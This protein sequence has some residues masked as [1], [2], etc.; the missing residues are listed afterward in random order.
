MMQVQDKEEKSSIS[1]GLL[2]RMIKEELYQPWAATLM[3]TAIAVQAL[4]YLLLT[5]N[6]IPGT[7]LFVMSL[8]AATLVCA[9]VAQEPSAR[10]RFNPVAEWWAA[11]NFYTSLICWLFADTLSQRQEPIYFS[12]FIL[13]E[14]LAIATL[15]LS[16]MS[17]IVRIQRRSKR[18]TM[19]F[20]ERFLKNMEGRWAR[21]IPK[22]EHNERE[23]I[24][25]AMHG[26]QYV[27]DLFDMG[28]FSLAVLWCCS[29]IETMAD[30]LIKIAYAR[31]SAFDRKTALT[32]PSPKKLTALGFPQGRA[33]DTIGQ[34]DSSLNTVFHEI[35]GKIA[36][37]NNNPSF[38]ETCKA[39]I[40][41]RDFLSDF[42]LGSFLGP[43]G[44]QYF[45]ETLDH[46]KPSTHS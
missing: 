7:L 25:G 11:L 15:L 23:V 18:D 39:M 12:L 20:D 9:L 35:R 36:H 34:V 38:D 16:F 30:S 1:G 19:K 29:T 33:S 4:T 41:L 6:D 40:V 45:R 26:I 21:L 43:E 17:L 42:D 46:F 5:D 37:H 3:A 28:M 10:V 22:E 8:I 14:T 32:L 27:T 44:L 31:S 24:L 13:V 2:S